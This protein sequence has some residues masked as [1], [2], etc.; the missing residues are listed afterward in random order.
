MRYVRVSEFLRKKE[1]KQL[2]KH[3]FMNIIKRELYKKGDTEMWIDKRNDDAYVD[4]DAEENRNL[5]EAVTGYMEFERCNELHN[6]VAP[7]SNRYFLESYIEKDPEFEQTLA[8]EF[9]IEWF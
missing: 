5:W 1:K 7:C 9:G 6:E 2:D 4:F 8:E 3:N